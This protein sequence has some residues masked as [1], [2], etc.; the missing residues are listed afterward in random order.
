MATRCM[1]LACTRRC[2]DFGWRW[3]E[4]DDDVEDN[5]AVHTPYNSSYGT[6][7]NNYNS[8]QAR[9]RCDVLPVRACW[10]KARL[11]LAWQD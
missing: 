10:R 5:V 7:T 4:G 8:S 11:R 3:T 9:S 1:L 6:A 2:R